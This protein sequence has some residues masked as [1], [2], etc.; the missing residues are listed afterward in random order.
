MVYKSLGDYQKALDYYNQAL[1]MIR[2]VGNR[3][4]E[5][6]TLNNIGNVYRSLGER[7]KAL[8]FLIRR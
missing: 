5:A 7:Q 4:G 2:V 8:D 1:T 3:S 6:S